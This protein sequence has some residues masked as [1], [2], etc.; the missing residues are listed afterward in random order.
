MAP[1]QNQRHAVTD[2]EVSAFFERI[3]L[4]TQAQR[5]ALRIPELPDT[6]QKTLAPRYIVRLS[7]DT[8]SDA[9]RSV[10]ADLERSAE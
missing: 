5:D 3:G 10:H 6:K 8:A 1:R 9:E 7:N 2:A 4:G